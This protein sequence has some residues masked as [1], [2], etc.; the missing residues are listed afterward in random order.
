MALSESQLLLL[1]CFMYSDLA[2]K[3][4]HNTLKDIIESYID[5]ETGEVDAALLEKADIQ[6]SGDLPGH[7]ERLAEILSAIYADDAL[8]SLTITHTTEEVKG[9]IRA[10]CFVDKDG[11]ATVAFRG[12][13]GSYRQWNNNFEG[14][15]DVS[16]QTQRDAAAFIR[17]LPY[18]NIDVTGHS[19]GGDQAMFVTIV[20]GDKI[21]RCVSFE[22][23]GVSKEFLEEYRDE[24]KDN[25]IK[26]KNICA[27]NDFVGLLL[28]DIAEETVYIE[29]GVGLLGGIFSHG[30]YGLW[31]K[32]KDK[33]DE[34]GDF[35][36]DA[37]VNQVWYCKGLH[38]LTVFLS[39]FSDKPFIGTFLELVSDILGVVVGGI[40]SKD[41]SEALND[42]VRDLKE[43]AAGL[44]ND[45]KTIINNGI[46]ALQ[47]VG[48]KIK[49][50]FSKLFSGSKVDYGTVIKVDTVKLQYYSQRLY[51]VNT[52]L[53][54]VD[55]R[56]DALYW[57]C[58]LKDLWNLIC[59]DFSIGN[60]RRILRCAEYLNE[61]AQL[62][63]QTESDLLKY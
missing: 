11:N 17:S 51:A 4:K 3:N 32:N 48:D 54:G 46:D 14:Y 30:S 13:G 49:D 29:S 22:G 37:Y 38:D 56:L 63:Y 47:Y 40:I 52:R 26:I 21:R 36:E 20:C 18:N 57:S 42:A 55:R 1:D 44:M 8:N 5:K 58:G 25:K 15:G 6:M 39:M 53:I 62:F 10:A 60:D 12:T 50:W 34:N 59:A 16:Q 33:I 2:P 24:I 23:Q 45:A 19:N 27:S 31:V 35:G 41:W 9:G 61:T 7:S 43:F 28:F